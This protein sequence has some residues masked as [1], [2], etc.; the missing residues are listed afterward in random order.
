MSNRRRGKPSLVLLLSVSGLLRPEL[1]LAEDATPPPRPSPPHDSAPHDS[2]PHVSPTSE[3]PTSEAPPLERAEAARE[4][5]H[6]GLAAYAE[7]RWRAAL[8]HF[9]AAER[10]MHS[11][12]FVLYAARCHQKLGQP[13]RARELYARVLEEPWPE[14]IPPAWAE[15][16]QS[17]ARELSELT[18]SDE[19]TDAAPH[20]PR[21]DAPR[22]D[23]P[24]EQRRRGPAA[25][26]DASRGPVPLN[27]QDLLLAAP[28]AARTEP[29]RPY[30][31]GA[32]AAFGVG[33]TGFVV[34]SLAGSLAW[35]KAHE[36]RARCEGSRCLPDDEPEAHE[37]R[38]L[39]HVATAGFV[40]AA[41]GALAGITLWLLPVP[42]G[43]DV[44][45]SL[46]PTRASLRATF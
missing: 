38:R 14:N 20:A 24:R 35:S 36:V 31:T 43:H 12:V 39:A 8:D 29:T 46:S 27:S 26:S 9:T 15:A 42:S 30:R 11:P 4:R 1:A 6:L 2:A 41:T 10:W 37:A 33:L 23:T 25:R 32:Y 13:Q 17:A 21:A 16:R 34:G 7:G 44:S 28:P 40:V 19:P 3:T 5:G 18:T 45:V 22:G